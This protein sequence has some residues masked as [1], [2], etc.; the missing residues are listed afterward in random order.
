MLV[1]GA[2]DPVLADL[3]VE[4]VQLALCG[5]LPRPLVL[6]L[7]LQV[8]VPDLECLLLTVEGLDLFAEFVLVGAG[9]VELL[10]GL[11]DVLHAP[12][13]LLLEHAALSFEALRTRPPVR[14][15]LFLV[16]LIDAQLGQL[17]LPLFVLLQQGHLLRLP[18]QVSL[19][20]LNQSV[21]I[22]LELCDS[23]FIKAVFFTSDEFLLLFLVLAQDALCFSFELLAVLLNLMTEHAATVFGFHLDFVLEVGQ[24]LLVLALLLALKLQDLTVR[25]LLH[26]TLLSLQFALVVPLEFIKLHIELSLY[27]ALFGLEAFDVAALAVQLL[28]LL[29]FEL[30]E[31]EVEALLLTL[32]DVAADALVTAADGQLLRL[33]LLLQLPLKVLEALLRILP[34]HLHLFVF[35]D[36]KLVLEGLELGVGFCFGL[37]PDLLLFLSLELLPLLPLLLDV[38][39][40]LHHQ[41]LLAQLEVLVDFLDRLLVLSL[42]C[43]FLLVDLL[44]G[45]G[46]DKRVFGLGSE[47]WATGEAASLS[48][49]L[50]GAIE[51]GRCHVLATMLGHLGFKELLAVD[52]VEGVVED[53]LARDRVSVV[54][55]VFLVRE[56]L[57]GFGHRCFQTFL[58]NEQQVGVFFEVHSEELS[59]TND[60]LL[61]GLIFFILPLFHL[62]VVLGCLHH[63]D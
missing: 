8:G 21:L 20:L 4:F 6:Q 32:L 43:A 38:L 58:R 14:L 33:Q 3:E 54:D 36:A 46:L 53:N 55:L 29:V 1:A 60:L 62:L 17:E 47:D 10:N 63:H 51:S 26:L 56:G 44:L 15:Q 9:N 18:L 31:L 52:L 45:F 28:V 5:P 39:L 48:L 22:L 40:V 23:F 16:V 27:L 19:V 30:L 34:D 37:G 41:L 25:R 57:P 49:T 24:L 11:L 2:V 50:F 59:V 35:L 13:L 12:A 61:S 7:R 42:D